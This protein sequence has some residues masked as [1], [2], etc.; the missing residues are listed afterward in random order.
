[1][2]TFKSILVTIF[3]GATILLAGYTGI[4]FG[5]EWVLKNPAEPELVTMKGNVSSLFYSRLEDDIQLYP[6]NYYPENAEVWN[7]EEEETEEYFFF[8]YNPFLEQDFFYLL[9]SVATGVNYEEISQWYEQQEKTILGSLVQ[10][11][12]DDRKLPLYFYEDVLT[13]EGRDYEVRISFEQIRINSFSCIQCRDTGVKETEEWKDKQEQL[14]EQLEKHPDEVLQV[15]GAMYD[16]YYNVD[17]ASNWGT[18]LALYME[19]TRQ[20][21]EEVFSTKREVGG[22]V[23]WKVHGD[24][25]SSGSCGDG[26]AEKILKEDI[27]AYEEKMGIT[28][29]SDLEERDLLNS[30]QIIELQDSILLVMESDLTVGLYYDV[31]EQQIVGFHFLNNYLRL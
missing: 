3:C 25:D 27:K 16:L 22:S 9:I 1:M 20:F 13:L 5:G 15:C 7:F 6:W 31:L 18:Y 26:Q 11:K 24:C 19:Y 8:G 30:M 23:N 10:G 29:A 14:T 17:L 21:E 12:M 4:I 2:K 28:N